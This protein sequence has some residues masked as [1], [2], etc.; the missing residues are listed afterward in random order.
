MITYLPEIYPDELVYSWFCR[1]YIHSGCLSHKMALSELYCKRSDCPSKEFIGNIN[2]EAKK[3]IETMYPMDT[4]ILKHTMY[5]QYARFIPLLQKNE[6]MYHLANDHCDVHHLF[7][8]LPKS[9]GEQFL[10]FCPICAKEDREKYGETYWHRK[11]QI[12]N[13]LICPK[14]RCKLEESNVT[15]KSV[16]TFTFCPAESHV[17]EKEATFISDDIAIRFAEYLEEVFDT[18]IDFEKDI[19]TSSVLYFGMCKT[20]YM[21]TSGRSRYTKSLSDDMK[22][23]YEKIGLHNIASMYQIQRALLNERY[24]FSVICQIAFFLGMQTDELVNSSLTIEQIR[25]EKD[26]HYQRNSSPINWEELDS[27]TAPLLELVANNIY[28]GVCGNRPERV[29]EKRIYREL[30]L[31]GHRLENMPKCREIFERYKESYPESWARKIIWAYKK[32]SSKKNE[33]FFWSDIRNL[34]GVKKCNF[35]STIPY[36]KMY[37]D[38]DTVNAI[39][40]LARIE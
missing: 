30:N 27:K 13:M 3:K 4:L 21:K 20:K 15:A 40:E 16:Q 24:D 17:S 35:E 9:D 7:S 25:Q 2:P 19:P 36:L 8:V 5:P 31:S 23:F 37:T 11:H 10:R 32:L 1:Y 39:I 14:H 6:A 33:S 34:S 29:S 26:S 12:R 38:K 22:D 18:P 28:Y